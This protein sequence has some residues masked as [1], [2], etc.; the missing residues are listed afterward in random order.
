MRWGRGE[1]VREWGGGGRASETG[2]RAR[3]MGG[4]GAREWG[5]VERVR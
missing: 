3:E 1:R 5:E 2:V 4:G